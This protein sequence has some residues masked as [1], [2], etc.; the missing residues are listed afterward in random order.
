M[1]QCPECR[2]MIP[3]DSAFCDKCGKELKWC[4]ECKRPKRGNEC[5]V[6]GSDLIPGRRYLAMLENGGPAP[7]QQPQQPPQPQ[8]TTE[9][10]PQAQPQQ[11][12]QQPQQNYQQQYQPQGTAVVT[13]QKT[14]VAPSAAPLSLVGNGWRL[15][16]REGGFGRVGGIWPELAACE[17]VSSSHGRI[18]KSPAG[19]TITDNG[20][21]NGTYVNG[22]RL[23]PGVAAVVNRG[24]SVRIATVEF[25]VE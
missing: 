1:T 20:S 11:Q 14:A 3:D 24:Y 18:A 13:P 12:Y 15:T 4:P 8:P 19:W 9:Y 7:V 2:N 22:E 17:F 16:F 21:T 5:P 6:C 10:R 25:T 23:S